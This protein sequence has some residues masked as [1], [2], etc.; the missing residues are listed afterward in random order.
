MNC[1]HDEL[2]PGIYNFN[3][4]MYGCPVNLSVENDRYFFQFRFNRELTTLIKTSLEKYKWHGYDEHNPRKVWSC[5]ITKRN[6][7]RLRFLL[8]QNVY[9]LYD[10]EISDI[11]FSRPLFKAQRAMVGHGLAHKR[12]EIAGE[13]GTGKTLAA[14]EIMERSGG[15]VWYWVGPKSALAAVQVDLRKWKCTIRPEFFTYEGFTKFINSGEADVPTGIV[16]DEASKLKNYKTKRTQAALNAATA[17]LDADGYLILMSGT[18]APKSPVDWWAQTEICCPGYLKEPSAEAMKYTMAF[19]EEA[20]GLEGT[21]FPKL[22]GWKDSDKRC[23][24][25][26]RF[27]NDPLHTCKEHEEIVKRRII[28]KRNNGV[29]IIE[30]EVKLHRIKMTKIFDPTMHDFIPAQNEV[31][32]LYRRLNGLVLPIFKKD[33]LDLPDKFYRQI[34]CS[35]PEDMLRSVEAVKQIHRKVTARMK[36]RQISDGF[37]YSKKK[38]G[39]KKCQACEGLGTIS[40]WWSDDLMCIVP[41]GTENAVYRE[42]EPCPECAGIGS[43]DVY[44]EFT[45]EIVSPKEQAVVDLLEEFEDGGRIIISAAFTASIDKLTALVTRQGWE[46]IRLDG[47][48]WNTSW[49]LKEPVEI[50]EAFQSPESHDKIAFI[51]HP[52]SGGMGL[53]LTASPAII[54]YSNTDKLEDRLQLEDRIHRPGMDVNRGACIIDLFCLDVDRTIYDNNGNKHD[55]QQL[56]LKGENEYNRTSNG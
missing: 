10:K 52:E 9:A 43:L 38:T 44:E 25:C 15:T 18:P 51:M 17:V 7:F 20:E 4:G 42:N 6:N 34:E 54:I 12:C 40:F 45:Q 39:T 26:G 3:V 47:R 2:T 5:A 8:G 23:E 21:T 33:C 14:I 48:G 49:G 31:A 37:L 46:F 55:L 11:Q 27:E 41:E 19:I 24:V 16:F 22:I 56:T 28:E 1:F 29:S 50:L 32:R 30:D 13:M 36:L 35:P 53:T